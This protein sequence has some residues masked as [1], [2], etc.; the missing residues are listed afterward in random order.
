MKKLGML[1]REARKACGLKGYELA[2]K[3][4]INPVYITQ[5]EK[6]DKLPSPPVM[7]RIANVLDNQALFNTYVSIKF[8]ELYQMPGIDM[9]YIDEECDKIEEMLKTGDKSE[10]TKN[11]FFKRLHNVDTELK[12]VHKKIDDME[13]ATS[14]LKGLWPEIIE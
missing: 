14:K 6:H 7:K 9:D 12:K 5:I 11:E 13:K 2:K 3:A 4:G 1:L 10:K 8:P